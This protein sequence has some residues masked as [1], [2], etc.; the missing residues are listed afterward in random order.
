MQD[1]VL[2]FANPRAY[3]LAVYRQGPWKEDLSSISSGP[4]TGNGHGKYRSGSPA[5]AC[6]T[7]TISGSS[8][9]GRVHLGFSCPPPRLW[10]ADRRHSTC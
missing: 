4:R 1:E 9:Q 8:A 3:E 7:P 2:V 6:P 10:K 5:K